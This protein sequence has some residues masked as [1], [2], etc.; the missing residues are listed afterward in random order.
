M[1]SCHS[2]LGCYNLSSGVKLSIRSFCFIIT[3]MRIRGQRTA[4]EIHHCKKCKDLWLL[5]APFGVNLSL[6]S[7]SFVLDHKTPLSLKIVRISFLVFQ[8][9]YKIGEFSQEAS[10]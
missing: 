3:Q 6:T 7:I 9:V 1:Y 8:K 4:F 5:L 10:I 2:V